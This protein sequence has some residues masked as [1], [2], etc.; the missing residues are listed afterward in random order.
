[1]SG[2]VGRAIGAVLI[3]LGF[4][5]AFFFS[6]GAM[7]G[8]MITMY[9][10]VANRVQSDTFRSVETY[11]IVAAAYLFNTYWIGMRMKLFFSGRP[12]AV[13]YSGLPPVRA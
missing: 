10:A 6:I 1:M 7:I 12:S 8:A 9:A 13:K 3:G 11:L 5:I 2:A 4:L